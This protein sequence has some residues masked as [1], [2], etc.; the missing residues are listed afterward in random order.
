MVTSTYKWYK[1]YSNYS[2]LNSQ[3]FVYYCYFSLIFDTIYLIFSS[4]TRHAFCV[5]VCVY[6][7]VYVC[8]W[9]LL[10]KKAIL[11]YLMDILYFI[12]LSKFW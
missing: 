11:V 8:V 9:C 1:T 2:C 6:V 10:I 7:C 3:V 12:F 5:H 4:K